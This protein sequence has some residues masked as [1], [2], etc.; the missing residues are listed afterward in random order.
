M[1]NDVNKLSQYAGSSLDQCGMTMSFRLQ[2]TSEEF[3][4]LHEDQGDGHEE[5]SL[6]SVLKLLG[7][8]DDPHKLGR[9]GTYE[10]SGRHRSWW[11]GSRIQ[12]PL[13]RLSTSLCGDQM[14]LPHL[15]VSGRST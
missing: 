10:V 3:E 11:Y 13:M 8:T 1:L 7:P 15:A 14:L 6:E 5:Q 9:I 4:R 12:G 2:T